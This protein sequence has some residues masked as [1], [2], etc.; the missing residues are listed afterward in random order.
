M[1]LLKS[2]IRVLTLCG[3]CSHYATAQEAPN[4]GIEHVVVI[5]FDGLSPDGLQN[6]HTPT[7]DKLMQEG[8][9]SLHA[10]AVLP[11]SSSSNWASMIMGAGPEQHGITSN[12][13]ER[14]NF[15]LSAVTQS[16]EF[17]FPTIFQL[18]HD[19][20]ASAEIGSIYHWGGFGRLFEKSAVDYD[21]NPETEDETAVLAS[22]YIKSKK[23]KLTFIHF[24]HVD[25]AGHEFGHGTPHYY[26]SVEKADAL[27]KQVIT[28]IKQADLADKT[29][30]IVSA[31]HGGLGKGHGGES[32]K[33][34]EIPF[35]VWG[36][37]VKQNHKIT[38]PVY[39]YD[40]AATVAFALGIKTPHAWIGKPIISAFQ[41]H[42]I[43]DGYTVLEQ[44]KEPLISPK[45]EGYKKAGGVFV[46][47]AS[48]KIENPN[49][50]GVIRY[51]LDGSLPTK[52]SKSYEKT[53]P[54]TQNTVVKSA[55]F[56]G[57]KINSPVAEAFFRI[58]PKTLS[59]PVK[60]EL[61]YMDKLLF[62]PALGEKKPNATGNTFEITS[63]EIKDK[64]KSNT[65]VRF[66]SYIQVKENSNYR[67]YLRSDDGS[68][69]FIDN[70]LIVDNDGDH[71]VKTKDGQI[72]LKPGKHAIKVL[73]FNGGGDGWLDVF[74]EEGDAAKQILTPPLLTTD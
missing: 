23:P 51:T 43:K 69:L 62:L 64:V 2:L 52:T 56:R 42:E 24:D 47:K 50:T 44:F 21:V 58:Q 15:T 29:L 27:L 32:L 12:A 14:D 10:R 31:D 55:M 17:I 1:K 28:A 67:F 59:K 19:Q 37:G 48:L 71:G 60:Y 40:N 57:G 46:E 70:Q 65:V 54:L 35:I 18:T 61:F 11:T 13:W 25:H 4:L 3:I 6:A 30:V 45:A 5:G 22:A 20:I 39:Q 73:W 16:E 36:K 49:V 74:V 8:A 53:I 63:D 34:I 26:E 7:F 66:T 9:Y 41:G 68:Q 33:E 72:N 38:H